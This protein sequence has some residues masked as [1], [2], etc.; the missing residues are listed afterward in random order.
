ME[1]ALEAGAD[2]IVNEDGVSTDATAPDALSAVA[3]G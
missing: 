3:E 1:I 2:D